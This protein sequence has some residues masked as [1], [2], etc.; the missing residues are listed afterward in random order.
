MRALKVLVAED[1]TINQR[2]VIAMLNALGH[3]GVVVG[4]GDKALKCLSKLTFDVV[5]MDVMMPQMDGL[6]ALAAIRLQEQATGIHL[7]VIMA[8]AHDEPG[9]RARYKKAGADGY[10]AKPIDQNALQAELQRVLGG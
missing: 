2:L 8:T 6:E 7:P 9:D 10:V 5:L 3:T 4:D 1:N